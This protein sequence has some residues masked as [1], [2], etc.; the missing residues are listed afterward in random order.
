MDAAEQQDCLHKPVTNGSSLLR[1]DEPQWID[2]TG[3]GGLIPHRCQDET[4]GYTVGLTPQTRLA[5]RVYYGGTSHS[6][7]KPQATVEGPH[8]DIE[9]K[10]ESIQRIDSTDQ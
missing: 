9:T 4:R 3:N 8:I 5:D 1:V 10:R 7:L 6:G 2:A